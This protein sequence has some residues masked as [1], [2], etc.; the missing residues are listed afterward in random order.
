MSYEKVRS[1][2]ITEDKVFVNCACN[3][4]RPL[5]YSTEE[6]PYFS[7][8]L[9]ENGREAVEIALL[10]IYEGGS[11]QQGTNKFSKALKVLRYVFGEEYKKFNWRNHNAKYGTPEREEEEK[12]RES[13][14]FNYLLK[15]ALDYKFPKNK[16]VITKNNFGEKIFGKS[17]LTCMKWS[18]FK[19]K[20]TKFDFKEEAEDHIFEKFKNEWEVEALQ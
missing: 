8:I 6:Y 16:F 10:K 13:E 9:Q 18:R 12:L 1:I 19:E 4:V 15:K 17:C 7:K 14:A 3:N 11:F 5:T 20:S 2:R